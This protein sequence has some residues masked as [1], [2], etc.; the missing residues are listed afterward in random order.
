MPGPVGGTVIIRRTLFDSNVSSGGG[1]AYLFGYAPD[2]MVLEKVYFMNNRA[3]G[4]GG[5]L[6]QANTDMTVRDCAFC[7]NHAATHGGGMMVQTNGTANISNSIF[8]DNKANQLGGGL[9][10][11]KKDGFETN[12]V[13]CTFSN[14]NAGQ[15][16]GAIYT[17]KDIKKSPITV[18][19]TIFYRNT[20]NNPHRARQQTGCELVDRG[21]N[22]QYPNSLTPVGKYD[23][24]STA[25]V[26]ILDVSLGPL[27]CIGGVYTMSLSGKA[28]PTDVGVQCQST[29]SSSSSAG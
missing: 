4:P 19:S 14:N 6:H 15:Y 23:N 16:G 24:N 12:L 22:I 2:T 17:W 27:E 9:L 13:S 7:K 26:R 11:D 5:G 21:G 18:R 10:T 8:Y 20:A 1:G 3:Q 28:A 25:S 29:S